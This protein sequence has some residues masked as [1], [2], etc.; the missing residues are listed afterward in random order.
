METT[1]SD[2]S[3]IENK[4]PEDETREQLLEEPVAERSLQMFNHL[5]TQIRAIDRLTIPSSQINA[6][7]DS[8]RSFSRAI[9]LQTNRLIVEISSEPLSQ[10]SQSIEQMRQSMAM[11]VQIDLSPLLGMWHDIGANLGRYAEVQQAFVN[12]YLAS[13]RVALPRIAID[14]D[15]LIEQFSRAGAR[16]LEYTLRRHHW[17]PVPGLPSEFYTGIFDLVEQAKTRRVNRYICDWFAWNRYRRLGR[18]VKRW[19]SNEYYRLRRHIIRQALKAHRR[20]WY[21]LT[22]PALIPLVEGIAKDYLQGEHGVTERS[23][24]LAVEKALNLNIPLSVFKEELRQALIRFLTS[25]TFAH[26]NRD[27]VLPSGYELNRHGVAHSRHLRYGTEANSLRCYLLLETLY[28]FI[29]D[30]QNI[31]WF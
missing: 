22:V 9:S 17:W 21:N 7:L 12:N 10:L 27:N 25:S 15:P 29:G 5:D 18:M 8:I 26:T 13:L 31:S 16:Q 3:E 6:V 28:Q 24:R 14:F 20:G 30:S 1:M 2:P 23:G 4:E 19:E 11:S